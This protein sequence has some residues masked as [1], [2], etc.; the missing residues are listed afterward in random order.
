MVPEYLEAS[1]RVVQSR[2]RATALAQGR[3]LSAAVQVP[4]KRLSGRPEF[5]AKRSMDLWSQSFQKTRHFGD[6][7]I[8]MSLRI[9]V[10]A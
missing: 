9:A 10:E 3:E 1:H 7:P 8:P 6:F 5:G 4:L 2:V